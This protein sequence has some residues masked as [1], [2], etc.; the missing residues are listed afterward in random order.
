[1]Q[2]AEAPGPPG[3]ALYPRI[4]AVVLAG[5]RPDPSLAGAMR[6]KAFARV[7]GRAIVAHV[8]D[9]LR[10]TP[11]IGRI[12]LVGP[13]PLPPDISAR[14]DTPVE[15]HGSLPA[16]VAAGLAA[17]GG[18]APVLAVPAD[19][20]LLS[21]RGVEAFLDGAARL[22]GDAWYAAI[23]R[24]DVDREF[25]GARKTFIRLADGVFCAGNL[26][27]VRPQAF[28]RARPMI[29]RAIRARKNPWALATLFGP[30]ALI[31]IVTGRLTLSALEE[32][33][34]RIA[35]IRVRAV[36][37]RCPE[38]AIDVDGRASL[39]FAERHLAERRSMVAQPRHEMEMETR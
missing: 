19:I 23:P 4:D 25:P 36:I 18:N 1:M 29:D 20:P 26:I 13:L 22:D 8:L 11:R 39:E 24:E 3:V 7:G 28:A 17:L 15:E 35:G 16:N 14:V 31:G 6:P 37:C 9:A 30:W 5:G 12:A 32:R 2:R 10:G 21:R 38:C 34:A 27:L 33:V